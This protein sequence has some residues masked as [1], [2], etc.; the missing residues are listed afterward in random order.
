[1]ASLQRHRT[2]PSLP[3]VPG[4]SYAIRRISITSPA[5]T[6]TLKLSAVIVICVGRHGDGRDNGVRRRRTFSK[7]GYYELRRDRVL[8]R[9]AKG[10]WGSPRC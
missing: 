6:L 4:A 3:R 2:V 9:L 10:G 8:G 5:S 7:E 1:V